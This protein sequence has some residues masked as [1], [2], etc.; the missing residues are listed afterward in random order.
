MSKI[1]SNDYQ[2]SIVIG[3][4]LM[5]TVDPKTCGDILGRAALYD[6]EAKGI[7]FPFPKLFGQL[8]DEIMIK[9]NLI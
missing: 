7:D 9:Y 3:W 5:K 8:A 2:L 4:E 1:K 6:V